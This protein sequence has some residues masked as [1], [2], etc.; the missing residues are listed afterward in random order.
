MKSQKF[1]PV[2]AT[3]ALGAA[4][5]AQYSSPELM[6]VLDYGDSTHVAK[7]DRYDPFSGQFLGSFGQNFLNNALSPSHVRGIQVVGNE[8]Y[9]GLTFNAGFSRIQRFNFSTGAFL[10]S[11]ADTSPYALSGFSKFGDHLLASDE[12]FGLGGYLWSYDTAGNATSVLNTPGSRIR[13]VASDLASGTAIYTGPT[14]LS[15]VVL[16]PDSTLVVGSTSLLSSRF[17]L[18]V[19]TNTA[20]GVTSYMDSVYDSGGTGYLE[21]RSTSGTLTGSVA[22][23]T[24]VLMQGLASGHG[25]TVYGI[26]GGNIFTFQNDSLFNQ[27]STGSFF[28]TQTNSAVGL[29]AYAAPEPAPF[30]MMGVGVLALVVKRR[31][32]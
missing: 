30:L 21:R 12:G 24:G 20:N 11:I 1:L 13:G 31:R 5:H 25:S 3:L 17:G 2:L 18:S 16:N 19:T 22:L 27:G 10:G 8:V 26:S 6:L 29:A 32:K 4:A 23:G 7:V 14:G 15:R 9:V 28:T